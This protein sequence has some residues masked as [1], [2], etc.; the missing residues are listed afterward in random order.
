AAVV[1]EPGEHGATCWRFELA[2]TETGDGAVAGVS[3]R[4]TC[5][6]AASVATPPRGELIMRG[7]SVA[8]PPGGC[9]Y[10]HRHQG[11]GIRCLFEGAIRI[12]T[13]EHST[14]YGPG[15]AWY[16]PGPDPVFAQAAPDR[17]TRFIRFMILPRELL[18]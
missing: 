8:F 17:P 4:S 11:P 3:V 5:K 9:A 13:Q 14:N 16:E 6:I 12:D 7:D 18:G 2:A 15:D 10:R 1:I